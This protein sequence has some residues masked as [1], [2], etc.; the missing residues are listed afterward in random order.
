MY[1]NRCV[2]KLCKKLESGKNEIGTFLLLCSQ[3]ASMA[4]CFDDT[5][6][7]LIVTV[8]ISWPKISWKFFLCGG[9]QFADL[10]FLGKVE[11]FAGRFDLTHNQTFVGFSDFGFRL[12][13][14]VS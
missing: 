14:L 7:H 3:F 4:S 1:I 12:K 11:R 2:L 5:A 10:V 9:I 8:V 6:G 13:N